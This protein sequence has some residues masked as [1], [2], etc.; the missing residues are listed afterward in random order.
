MKIAELLDEMDGVSRGAGYKARSAPIFGRGW[1]EKRLT[2][3]SPEEVE[4]VF[5][6]LIWLFEYEGPVQ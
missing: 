2:Q 4:R 3:M 6:E 5:D 1:R